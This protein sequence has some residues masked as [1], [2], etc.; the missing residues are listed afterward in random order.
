MKRYRF[1]VFSR[2]DLSFVGFAEAGEPDIY[3]DALVSADSTVSCP[4]LFSCARGDFAQIRIDGRVYFQGIITD[5]NYDGTKTDFTLRQMIEILNTE[6]FADVNLLKAQPI[7]TWFGNILTRVFNGADSSA[8]LPG[9]T[10][11]AESIT[12]G[13]HAATDSGAYNLYDLAI[14]FFKVYGV[15]LDVSFDYNARAVSFV[16][17]SVQLRVFKL[18]LSVS[19]VL[20]YS[21]EPSIEN[22]SPN[23]VVIQDEA[24]PANELTYYWHPTDFSGTIDT[25][26]D[27]NRVIPVKTQCDVVQLEEGDTFADVAYARAEEILYQTRYDDLIN[28]VIRADSKLITTWQIGQQYTLY[29]HGDEYNTLLTGIH[30]QSM[31]SVELTFGY[32]RKRLT[33][34]LKMRRQNS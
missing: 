2:S 4:G 18:D 33:Q 19:D 23:K 20:E 27:T 34:I 7:E 17:S 25:D 30:S 5:W 21:I 16:F 8:R 28:V 29:D 15:I 11:T 31:A 9:F 1:E 22:D 13:T 32:V 24:N 12:N 14:Y 6:A 26:A 10:I 3:I